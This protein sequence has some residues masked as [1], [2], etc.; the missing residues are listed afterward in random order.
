MGTD[1]NIVNGQQVKLMPERIILDTD[2][3]TDIDDAVALSL[4]LKSPEIDLLGVTTVYAD[5]LFRARM[6]K[7]MLRLA[8]REDIPVRAGTNLPLLRKLKPHWAGYEGKGLLDESDTTLDP[9]PGHAVDFIIDTVMASPGE[10]TLV[11]IGPLTNIALAIIKEP[12]IVNSVKRL[13]IMGGAAHILDNALDIAVAEWNILC[14][15]DAASVVFRSGIPMTMVGLDV[16]TKTRVD[17]SHLA[18]LKSRGTGLTDALAAMM[19]TTWEN[20]GCDGSPMH[21]PLAMSILIDP[22]LVELQ[23]LKVE[24]TTTEPRPG[25]TIVHKFPEGEEVSV[26]VAVDSERFVDLLMERLTS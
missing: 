17:L 21:D 8:G 10:V 12:A 24:V 25:M 2:I 14:D 15:P 22:S 18:R 5:T 1:T 11:A 9:E 20:W 13:V 16:T 6:V 26:A 19:A 7:K 3:G 4:A 23:P